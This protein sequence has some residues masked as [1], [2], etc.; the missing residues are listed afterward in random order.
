MELV[1]AHAVAE[2]SRAESANMKR[3]RCI[4]RAVVRMWEIVWKTQGRQRLCL[5]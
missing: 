1:V 5:L 4:S 2:A 3:L